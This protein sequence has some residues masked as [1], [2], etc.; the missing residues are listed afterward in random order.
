MRAARRLAVRL[1]TALGLLAAFAAAPAVAGNRPL[2]TL[3]A[4]AAAPDHVPGEI[5]VRFKPTVHAQAQVSAIERLGG[6]PAGTRGRSPLLRVRLPAGQSAA[7]AVRAYAL[8]PDVEAAQLNYIY[9]P[10]AVPNDTLFDS[11]W[12]LR[13]SGQAVSGTTGTFGDDLG[14]VAAWDRVT[15][16]SAVVVAVLDTGVNYTHADLAA[17]MWDGGP[18]YPHHGY[19]AVDDDDDP[20][21]A[22]G[23]GHGTHVAGTIGAEGNNGIGASGVCWKVQLMAVRVMDAWGGTTAEVVHG[24]EFAVAHGAKVINFS[25]GG[26][27]GSADAMFQ[28][29][30]ADAGDKDV[31]VVV[32]AGNASSDDDAVPLAPCSFPEPNLICVAALDQNLELAGFSNWGA[33]SVDVGAPGVNILS[34]W[35]G[36]TRPVTIGD[37]GWTKTGDWAE[38]TCDFGYGPTE[39]LS[40]PSGWCRGRQYRNSA[41]DV[42]YRSF[43]LSG[44]LGAG[45]EGYAFIDTE[46]SVD[47]LAAAYKRG[48]GNPFSGGTPLGAFS[49]STGGWAAPLQMSL[50]GCAGASCTL[51]FRLTSDAATVASGAALF[52]LGI[53]TAVAGSTAYHLLQGTSMASPHVAGVAALL[54]AYNPAYTA[55][56]VV[57]AIRNGGVPVSS[58][59]GITVTGRAVNAMGSLAYI[60]KPHGLTATVR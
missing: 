37:G 3:P 23:S 11:Q 9:R 14:A 48:G 45:L 42:A 53:H 51:G 31:V 33:Q 24:I 5:L 21:P 1:C 38:S 56:D 49:G 16:C 20:M 27:S 32:A 44:T 4:D 28:A 13:N 57:A 15:D 36:P 47:V 22:D 52:E 41:D 10:Q 19:D 29:A 18:G 17:N 25:G 6:T 39:M 34:T 54:R 35:P 26:P 60:R 30:I 2:V 46:P 55:A 12:A 8:D 50:A 58:L 43:D 40:D 59:S 7:D